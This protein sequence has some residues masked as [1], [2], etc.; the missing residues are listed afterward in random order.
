MLD[1][2]REDSDV[3]VEEIDELLSSN[4]VVVARVIVSVWECGTKQP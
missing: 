4:V 2:M 1:D 3:G